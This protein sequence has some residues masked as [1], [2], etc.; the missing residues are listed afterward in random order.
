MICYI[1]KY[2]GENFEALKSLFVCLEFEISEF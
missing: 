1:L 2:L